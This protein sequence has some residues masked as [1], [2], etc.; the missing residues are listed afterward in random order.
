MLNT[1]SGY[2]QLEEMDTNVEGINKFYLKF[3]DKRAK[4]VKIYSMVSVLSYVDH[5]ML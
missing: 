4:E 5:H 3:D 2:Q 1:H